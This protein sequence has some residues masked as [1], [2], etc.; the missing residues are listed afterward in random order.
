MA[1]AA[2][3]LQHLGHRRLLLLTDDTFKA[4]E[5]M[6]EELADS[7]VQLVA[8]GWVGAAYEYESARAVIRGALSAPAAPTGII[9]SSDTLAA[10]AVA[11]CSILGLRVPG[12]ISIVGFGDTS[13]AWALRPTLTTVRVP[14]EE[15][16]RNAADAVLAGLGGGPL[17]H[18]EFPVRLVIRESS[19][20]AAVCST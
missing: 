9:C 17:P 5:A 3:Y 7:D 10:A 6:R 18:N 19:G 4:T 20:A 13:L 12:E 16:G 8:A 2:R 14:L 11:E 1:L 15:M